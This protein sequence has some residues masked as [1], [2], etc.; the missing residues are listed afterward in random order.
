MALICCRIEVFLRE[1]QRFLQFLVES[2]HCALSRNLYH[3]P[4]RF[5]PLYNRLRLLMKRC[6]ALADNGFI[7]II[8]TPLVSGAFENAL[9]SIFLVEED[10]HTAEIP[11][12]LLH[13]GLE[14]PL[15]VSVPRNAFKED[16]L[17]LLPLPY[18]FLH[19]LH[20]D[21]MRDELADI[22]GGLH[23]FPELRT[24]CRNGTE[25]PSCF[26]NAVPKLLCELP[27]LRAFTASLDAEENKIHTERGETLCSPGGLSAHMQSEC[28][29]NKSAIRRLQCHYLCNAIENRLRST[30][31]N[32]C[33]YPAALCRK[34][35]AASGCIPVMIHTCP[36]ALQCIFHDPHDVLCR[37]IRCLERKHLRLLSSFPSPY[38]L[39]LCI[40]TKVP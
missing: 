32:N 36:H 28:L 31:P 25:F 20:D 16:L 8:C 39:C 26:K 6:H 3:S 9:Q 11:P 13:D 14:I 27:R 1:P 24:G 15:L 2:F 17:A 23:R 7:C 21:L 12:L 19:H 29:L 18:G 4:L 22:D 5:I 40:E 35:L 37:P 10:V 38:G 33:S 30:R 34:H